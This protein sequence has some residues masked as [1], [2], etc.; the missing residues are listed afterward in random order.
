MNATLKTIL[1]LAALVAGNAH[2][3]EVVIMVGETERE[4]FD[5]T[6]MV[7]GYDPRTA[8]GHAELNRLRGNTPVVP[9][10]DEGRIAGQAAVA[11]A[12]RY[13]ARL[14]DAEV[15]RRAKV[16]VKAAK[17]T[18]DAAESFV[19]AF[20]ATFTTVRMNAR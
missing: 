6:G 12:G 20:V 3:A 15:M 16:A 13:A 9:G 18:G 8:A 5:R 19:G 11:T 1:I 7:R 4:A 2:A 14:T 17:L 10:V